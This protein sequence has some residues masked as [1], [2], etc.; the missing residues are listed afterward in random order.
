MSLL[1]ALAAHDLGYLTTA[2]LLERLDRTLKTLEGLERYRGHFL[3][4]YDTTTL[5]PLHP[6]YVSSVDSGNLAAALIAI[7]EGLRQLSDAAPDALRS[8]SLACATTQACS[9]IAA[10]DHRT[11]NGQSSRR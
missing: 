10:S 9:T 4:W 1:S 5:S 8:S 3:N 11:R 6:R 7:A 2:A